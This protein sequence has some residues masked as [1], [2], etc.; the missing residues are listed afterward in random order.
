MVAF[1]LL[2]SARLLLPLNDAVLGQTTTPGQ[3]L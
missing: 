1:V 3:A 2:D